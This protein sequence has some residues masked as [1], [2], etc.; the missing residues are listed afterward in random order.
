LRSSYTD[1]E[2]AKQL[3]YALNDHMWGMK[4]TALEESIDFSTID[5]EKLFSRLKSYELSHQ[6]RTNHDASFTS[7]ALILVL[8]L[9][10]MMLTPP[11]LSHLL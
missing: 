6:C 2:R 9:V 1:N 3:L 10:V 5:I 11:M 7:K 8:V 4:I